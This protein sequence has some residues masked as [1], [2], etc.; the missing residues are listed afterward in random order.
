MLL[1]Q[2]EHGVDPR[3]GATEVQRR[4]PLPAE[5][6]ARDGERMP[7]HQLL[8]A[9]AALVLLDVVAVYAYCLR[10]NAVYPPSHP[11]SGITLILLSI[12]MMR[13]Q[14]RAPSLS[15]VLLAGTVLTAGLWTVAAAIR[16]S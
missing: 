15:W 6:D 7:S 12:G 1:A 8:K 10:V 9:G 13:T 5:Q 16:S 3:R 11:W 4:L 14:G 2:R